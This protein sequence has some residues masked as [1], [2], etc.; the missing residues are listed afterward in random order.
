MRESEKKLNK[1]WSS[2]IFYWIIFLWNANNALLTMGATVAIPY[3]YIYIYIYHK[4]KSH[5][6]GHAQY[7]K[8]LKVKYLK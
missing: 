8:I 5:M 6:G 7:I 1:N 2:L 3:I 4:G